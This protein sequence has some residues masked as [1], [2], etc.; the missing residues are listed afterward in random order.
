VELGVDAKSAIVAGREAFKH[1]QQNSDHPRS[2]S[3][4]ALQG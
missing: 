1:G 3:R 4:T 2:A